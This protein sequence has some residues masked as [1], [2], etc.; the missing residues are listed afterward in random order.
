MKKW[1]EET[2]KRVAAQNIGESKVIFL[3]GKAT[4]SV[5]SA[6]DFLVNHH[7]YIFSEVKLSE[8]GK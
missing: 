5:C 2:A 6:F 7:G 8:E 1:T 4:L 3:D